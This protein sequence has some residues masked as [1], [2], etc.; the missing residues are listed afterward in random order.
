MRTL[1]YVHAGASLFGFYLD[2]GALAPVNDGAGLNSF[3]AVLD[4][5]GEHD[6]SSLPNA[7]RKDRRASD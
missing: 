6:S 1:Y 4:W 2:E 3:G 5:A 7:S